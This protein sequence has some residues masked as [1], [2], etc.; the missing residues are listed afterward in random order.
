MM[1]SYDNELERLQ[2]EEF[3]T[4]QPP[5]RSLKDYILSHQDIIKKDIPPV[6]Y[7]LAQWLPLQS[8]G[9]VYAKPAVGKSWFC[10][11]LVVAIA[12]AYKRFLGWS[13]NKQVRS[14][15]VDGEMSLSDIKERFLKLSPTGLDQIDILASED[16]FLEGQPL[17]LDRPDHQEWFH[18]LLDDLEKDGRKPQVIVF[19]NLS[20][21]RNSTNEND[22]SETQRLVSWLV[23][24]RARGFTVL[25]VHHAGKNGDQR[26]ASILTVPMNYVV[27]LTKPDSDRPVR[28][29]ETRFEVSFDKMRARQPRPYEFSAFIGPDEAGVFQL[30]FNPTETNI[31]ARYRLLRLIGKRGIQTYR[32]MAQEIDVGH[33]SIGNYL[34]KLMTEG[35][36]EGQRSDPKISSEGWHL[37][38]DFW[39][40]EFVYNEQYTFVQSDDVPF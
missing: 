16:M 12:M 10:M 15:Y 17:S 4:N 3:D 23:S 32:E 31:E 34:A 22:N 2:A 14:L 40:D 29:G 28:E 38:Y 30:T 35:L 8:L 21:L 11:A 37:L 24:L 18:Q 6:E 33:S 27:K 13:I 39:P 19:D 20:T 25:V 36:L 7:L 9:M 5:K 26:G 1:D